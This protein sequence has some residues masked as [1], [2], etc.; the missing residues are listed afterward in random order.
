M[1][2]LSRFIVGNKDEYYDLLQS[3]RQQGDWEPWLLFMLKGVAGTAQATLVTVR[4]VT[5]RAQ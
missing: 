1:L 4:A 2:C 3:T 5:S